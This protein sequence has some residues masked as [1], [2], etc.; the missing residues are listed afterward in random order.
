MAY[1]KKF[2]QNFFDINKQFTPGA[3]QDAHE[4][5]SSLLSNL[6]ES[7]NQVNKNEIKN[8]KNKEKENIIIEQKYNEFIK[9]ELEKNKSYIYNLF[10]GYYI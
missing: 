2:I 1:P 8:E 5:L 6:H 7:L 3:E 10:T 4:F 9:E